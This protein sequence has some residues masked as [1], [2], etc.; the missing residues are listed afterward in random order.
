MLGGIS[1]I[2]LNFVDILGAASGKKALSR[3]AQAVCINSET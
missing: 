3:R 2:L 1:Y